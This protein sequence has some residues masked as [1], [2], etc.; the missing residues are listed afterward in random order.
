MG[1]QRKTW[2]HDFEEISEAQFTLFIK[3]V[4]R[5]TVDRFGRDYGEDLFLRIFEDGNPTGHDFY[6]QL[7]GTD[8]IQQYALKNSP[9]FSYSVDLVCLNQWQGYQWP[10]VFVLWDITQKTGYWLH[11]QPFV[12]ETLHSKPTWS[13]NSSNAKNPKR[14][15]RI[16]RSNNLC[17]QQV[18]SLK[19][20]V[21]AEYE[22]TK[23]GRE[24]FEQLREE[25][26][27]E[28][29]HS[30]ESLPEIV[31]ALSQ[32]TTL[33]PNVQQQLYIA[34]YQ[35]AVA[36]NPSDDTSWLGLAQIYYDLNE[37]DK[38]VRTIDRAWELDQDDL[39]IIH[40]R[41][42]ILTE[43]A[44]AQDEKP[45]SMLFE[46]ISLFESMWARGASPAVLDYNIGNSLSALQEH[47][48]AIEHF[49]QALSE[50]PTSLLAAQI[51]K[52]RG[53]AFYHL[54]DHDEE[55][56]SYKQSLELNP[57]LWEAY[58]SWGITEMHRGNLERARDLLT[59]SF[60]VNPEVERRNYGLLYSLAYIQWKLGELAEAYRRVNQLLAFRPEHKD[61]LLLKAH[62]LANLW[63]I[64]PIYIPSAISF[65]KNR[66]LDNPDDILARS[67]LY[68]IYNSE[69]YEDEARL[70]LEETARLDEAPPQMLYRY[71][72]LLEAEQKPF[73]AIG[74]LEVAF[75]QWQ[76]HHIVHAL[77][78]LKERVGEYES[79]IHY[80]GLAL[81][82]VTNP[83]PILHSIGDCYHFLGNHAECVRVTCTAIL[84]A[85]QD[86]ISWMNLMYSLEQLERREPFYRFIGHLRRLQA[87]KAMSS[88]EIEDTANE[89][90][91]VVRTEFGDDFIQTL[92]LDTWLVE[93]KSPPNPS[94][95]ATA[96][97]GAG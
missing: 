22:K 31:S 54:G 75:R 8:S 43:Y 17:K 87:G 24:H 13:D 57:N 55:I 79:A 6:V 27:E 14:N 5:W 58:A 34:Q 21:D 51:W 26:V 88:E 68:W 80:Y 69:G 15:I 77:G 76:A 18:G 56:R 25:R 4:L 46:A 83:L 84:I 91:N 32:C 48:K 11:I 29:E 86:D 36:S 67:E 64:D 45:K 97:T 42:C 94:L 38:A 47:Q 65:F 19:N 95:E 63:E 2:Q 89:L 37:L 59:K 62:L 7:K 82:D 30:L 52:N 78:R 93:V 66:I 72:M 85:P 23:R 9:S 16:P 3:E 60:L 1:Q 81:Q 61:G 10:V 92:S 96:P 74:Y 20:L 28:I 41:A 39:Q 53:T 90:L 44:A 71:A 50:N 70:I 49:D 33:P 35:A 12:H 73:E 40:S